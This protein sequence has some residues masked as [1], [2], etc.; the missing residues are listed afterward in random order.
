MAKQTDVPTEPVYD[1]VTFA[2]MAGGPT[3]IVLAGLFHSDPS[4]LETQKTEG[5]WAK[6]IDKFLATPVTS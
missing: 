5:E 4:L 3:K 6:A 1:G 2:A